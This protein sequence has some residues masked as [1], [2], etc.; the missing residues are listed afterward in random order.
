MWATPSELL[1][2][3]INIIIVLVVQASYTRHPHFYEVCDFHTE[4]TAKVHLSSPSEPK[5]KGIDTTMDPRVKLL[6][7]LIDAYRIVSCQT[8]YA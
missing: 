5:G 8:D 2:I 6:P 1:P 4:D 7:D 3:I